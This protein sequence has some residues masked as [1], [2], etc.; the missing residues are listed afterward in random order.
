MKEINKR[1]TETVELAL[2]DVYSKIYEQQK[3]IDHLNNSIA[4]LYERMNG[5]EHQLIIQKVQLVGLGPSV[6]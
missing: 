2:K 5:L 4:N 3:I 6:K 1:N